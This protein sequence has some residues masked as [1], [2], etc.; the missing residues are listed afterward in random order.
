MK[1]IDGSGDS[2]T[3]LVGYIHNPFL[4][5]LKPILNENE[6]DYKQMYFDLLNGL[7]ALVEG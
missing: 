7:K 4:T 5:E 2:L 6:P 3:G 1:R